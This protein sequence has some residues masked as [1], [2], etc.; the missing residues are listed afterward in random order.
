MAQQNSGEANRQKLI[1]NFIKSKGNIFDDIS[2]ISEVYDI[3]KN[4]K[5]NKMTKYQYTNVLGIRAT[6]IAY[7]AQIKIEVTPDMKSAEQVAEEELRQKK[8]P[9]FVAKEINNNHVDLW[10]IEDMEIEPV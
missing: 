4:I 2:D 6:Q 7:G 9:F 3:K 1:R 5:N 10:R 8:T